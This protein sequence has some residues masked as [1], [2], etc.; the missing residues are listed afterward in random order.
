MEKHLHASIPYSIEY[1]PREERFQRA[2]TPSFSPQTHLPQKK[3]KE[4][5]RQKD[6]SRN[7]YRKH[8]LLIP[9]T[10]PRSF[11]S[12]GNVPRFTVKSA[13]PLFPRHACKPRVSPFRRPRGSSSGIGIAG[14]TRAQQLRKVKNAG[15]KIPNF[16]PLQVFSRRGTSALDLS[17]REREREMKL[18]RCVHIMPGRFSGTT[19]NFCRPSRPILSPFPLPRVAQNSLPR[20][21]IPSSL[22]PSF[23][24]CLRFSPSRPLVVAPFF[25]SASVERAG[26]DLAISSD[27]NLRFFAW[28]GVIEEDNFSDI[29][30][31]IYIYTI[32]LRCKY[33]FNL[34]IN[35]IPKDVNTNLYT[36]RRIVPT[37]LNYFI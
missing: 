23:L 13:A 2:S 18:H 9:T 29:F 31:D 4:K 6:R 21:F 19:R 12:P 32:F 14:T 10:P 20:F 3:K 15:T 35:V 36:H 27:V 34:I 7:Y 33:S 25:T 22:F 1:N 5:E 30:P 24:P 17:S 16:R 37:P 11:N 28:R 26:L 8:S